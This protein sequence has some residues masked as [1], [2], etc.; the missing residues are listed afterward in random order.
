MKKKKWGLGF[1]GL[2]LFFLAVVIFGKPYGLNP[3]GEAQKFLGSIFFVDSIT[4]KQIIDKYLVA[5]NS[6]EG[7]RV[8]I[9][10]GHDGEIWGTEFNGTKEADLNLELGT[11]LYNLMKNDNKFQVFITRNENGYLPEFANFFSNERKNIEKF[12]ADNF[13]LMDSLVKA[14]A[15][16]VADSVSHNY[17]S[18]ETSIKLSGINYWAN[19]NKIDVVISIHFNDYGGRRNGQPG[20]YSGYAIYVPESQYS[21]SKASQTIAKYISKSLSTLLPTSDL[22]K[23]GGGVVQDQELISVGANNTLDPAS[24]LIE[25]GYIY[26]N[27]FINPDLRPAMMKELAYLTYGGMK[28]F[29]GGRNDMNANQTTI[30]PFHFEKTLARKDEGLDVLALQG[31]LT[32]ENLYPPEGFSKNDCTMSGTFGAGTEKSVVQFQEKYGIAPAEG[33]VGPMTLNKLNQL[34]GIR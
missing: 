10:P 27:Q 31:A 9:V 34:Y 17:A 5:K 16:K 8:L 1:L 24:L 29:L 32:S 13:L 23:E 4:D 25:Y 30:L 18:N 20:R 15:V 19:K 3:I 6:G 12:R 2:T 33:N 26:E 7:V 14:G 28:N 11:D 21:N 22:P